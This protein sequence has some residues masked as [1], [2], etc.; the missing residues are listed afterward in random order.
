MLLRLLFIVLLLFSC[1]AHAENLNDDTN[2]SH[3][4][5]VVGDSLS[6]EYG[7]ETGIG[8][9]NLL[10]N[11]LQE[12]DTSS[13][14]NV[15]NASISGDTTA[16]GLD[17]LP[18]LIEN[19]QPVLC[20]IALGANDGLRGLP[21]NAMQNNLD[22]M[23]KQCQTSGT[24]LLVGMHLPPN[25]GKAYTNAF[26]QVYANVAESNDINHVPFMLEGIALEDKYFQA[27]RL[28]PTAEAQPIILENIW[29][30]LE[31]ILQQF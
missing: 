5:L 25:Y 10:H 20:I 17:R 8:W 11:R 21:I 30:Q 15:V 1:S 2:N 19:Y 29:V 7:I 31:D 3:H 6:A 28:H 4:I 27:D 26:H 23:V 24:S 22:N 12:Q 18:K 16:G 13:K 14:W 9:V